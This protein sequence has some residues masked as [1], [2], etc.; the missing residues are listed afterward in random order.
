[1][2]ILEVSHNGKLVTRAGREDL[3]VLNTIVDAVGV[4]GNISAGTKDE[5]D[6][7]YLHLRVGG[8]AATSDEDPGQ[9]L[10][11]VSTKELAV[12]DE[13]TIR[14]TDSTEADAALKEKPVDKEAIVDQQRSIWESA[15]QFYLQYKDEFENDG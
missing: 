12:G 8:L 9:H 7:F 3:C 11:W 13:I 15:K 2:I 5:K 4:L 1:M 10:E 14:I 6:D